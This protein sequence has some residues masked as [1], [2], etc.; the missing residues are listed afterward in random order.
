ML[1]SVSVFV[2]TF[3]FVSVQYLFSG[4]L[5]EHGMDRDTGMDMYMITDTDMIMNKDN[6]DKH[7][8]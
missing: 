5:S 2:F 6:L 8:T 3:M 4:H 1:M 7:Y